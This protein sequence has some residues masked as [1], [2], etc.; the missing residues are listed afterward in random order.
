MPLLAQN[1]QL[2]TG[3]SYQ[4]TDL[5]FKNGNFAQIPNLGSEFEF[6]LF[7][8]ILGP[9][10]RPKSQNSKKRVLDP[11][12]AGPPNF[13]FSFSESQYHGEHVGTKISWCTPKKPGFPLQAPVDVNIKIKIGLLFPP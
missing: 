4:K 5:T 8:T 9:N 11:D 6:W 1:F 13:I 3:W 12:F 10:S 7:L 2:F